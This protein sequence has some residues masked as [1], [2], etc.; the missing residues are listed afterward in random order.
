[1]FCFEVIYSDYKVQYWGDFELFSKF[2]LDPECEV[3]LVLDEE[4]V[5]PIQQKF[6]NS[7]CSNFRYINRG[8]ITLE[9]KQ[10]TYTI[11]IQKDIETTYPIGSRIR[12]YYQPNPRFWVVNDY[13]IK[14]YYYGS[15][16]TREIFLK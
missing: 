7:P 2:L 4:L 15:I 6:I 16:M 12:F 9:D 13:N 3:V 11:H 14:G 10:N 8:S 5:L 1:M